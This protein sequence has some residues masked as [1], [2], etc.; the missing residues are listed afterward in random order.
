[1]EVARCSRGVDNS[2]NVAYYGAAS[3]YY[4]ARAVY[5]SYYRNSLPYPP[6]VD[7]EKDISPEERLLCTSPASPPPLESWDTIYNFGELVSIAVLP[8]TGTVEGLHSR[9]TRPWTPW[10]VCHKCGSRR[11]CALS[12]EGT[13]ASSR[14]LHRSS[15]R[16]FTHITLRTHPYLRSRCPSVQITGR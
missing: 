6:R 9:Y 2:V 5:G 3:E 11:C 1:V 16:R 7:P 10:T 13:S 14:H 12:T 8:S 15:P 4:K